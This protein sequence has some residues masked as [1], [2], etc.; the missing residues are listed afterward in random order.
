MN[1]TNG[2][3]HW[4]VLLTWAVHDWDWGFCNHFLIFSTPPKLLGIG[5]TECVGSLLGV[6]FLQ[7][8]HIT[9]LLLLAVCKAFP[10]KAFGRSRFLQK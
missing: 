2:V 6:V 3:A 1:W 4:G 8:G 9:R 7:S 10:A 5:K